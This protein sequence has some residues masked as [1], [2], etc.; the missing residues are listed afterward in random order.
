ME[1]SN[2]IADLYELV[3]NRL[4]ETK[5]AID[6]KLESIMPDIKT[7]DPHSE[8]LLKEMIY[9][10]AH[11]AMVGISLSDGMDDEDQINNMKLEV[12]GL[13]RTG[14]KLDEVLHKVVF[15]MNF[16]GAM[17][18]NLFEDIELVRSFFESEI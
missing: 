7:Q 18:K 1:I 14:L 9:I 16:E 13:L 5:K 3:I 17:F 8:E 15:E 2:A 11:V 4:A 12:Y 10:T 6:N